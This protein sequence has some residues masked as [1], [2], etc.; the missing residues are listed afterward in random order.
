MFCGL[1][2]DA[3]GLGRTVQPFLHRVEDGFVL[4]ALDA[5]FLGS[6]ALEFQGAAGALLVQ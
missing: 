3:H 4:P 6:R 2:A 1:A 5:P